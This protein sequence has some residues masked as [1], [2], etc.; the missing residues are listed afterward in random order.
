MSATAHTTP[1]TDPRLHIFAGIA[2]ATVTAAVL[3]DDSGNVTAIAEAIDSAEG[4]GLTVRDAVDDGARV[5]PGDQ[6]LRITGSPYQV[7]LA[8]E[9]LIGILAKP[10]GIATATRRFVERANGRVRIVS[11]AWKK[12]PFSQKEMIRSAILAGG[13]Q[14]RIA[15]WPFAYLDKNFVRMLG[16]PLRTLAAVDGLDGFT[17]IIQLGRDGVGLVA[18]AVDAAL[19]GA[20]VIFIDT[21]H[22]ADVER[23]AGA[24]GEEG[25]R[26]RVAI[27]FGGGI[28]L[29]DI[30]HL[31]GMDIDI[32]DIGRPIVDAPLLDLRLTVLGMTEATS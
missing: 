22:R 12:L 5:T 9:R 17:R 4:L 16:G 14:P 1:M 20:N 15:E 18:D 27:A 24:L 26:D 10:S 28:R 31:A 7:A 23:V 2:D 25:V 3:A 29:E 8:E 13:A 6:I 30:D 21:G 19:A 32:L 11:G